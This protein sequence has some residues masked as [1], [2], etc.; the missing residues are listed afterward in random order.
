MVLWSFSKFSEVY[1][2]IL[3]TWKRALLL[4][5]APRLSEGLQLTLHVMR[6]GGHCRRVTRTFMKLPIHRT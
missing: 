3:L 4:S 1:F 2:L 6:T 5:T